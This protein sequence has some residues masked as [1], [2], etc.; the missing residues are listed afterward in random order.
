MAEAAE[1]VSIVRLRVVLDSREPLARLRS[2]PVD[3]GLARRILGLAR[4]IDPIARSFEEER[5]K[6]ASRLGEPADQP[7]LWNL[8]TPEAREKWNIEITDVLDREVRV[9][10]KLCLSAAD[11]Q[12]VKLS[13]DDLGR[14][15]YAMSD[16]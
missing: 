3:V 16:M 9:P 8:K 15:A 10:L 14:L 7:N 2:Q 5:D 1:K 6:I 11:L 4:F 12:G 13:A